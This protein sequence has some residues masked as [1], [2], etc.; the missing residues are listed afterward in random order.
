[1]Y[2]F[3]LQ[4]DIDKEIFLKF[5]HTSDWHLGARL[6]D[7]SRL[8]EQ[9]EVLAEIREIAE[10]E[11]VDFILLAGDIFDTFNPPNEAV[12]LLYSE[13]KKMTAGGTRPVVAI[14]G[15][16]D[17]PDRIESP[18]PLA[19]ECG[20]FFAGYPDFQR[21]PKTLDC[22]ITVSFPEAGV[23]TIDKAGLPQI[24]LLLTPYANEN[25]LRRFLAAEDRERQI[26]AILAENWERLASEYC[27]DQGVNILAAH[28]F[29]AAGAEKAVEPD[30]ERSILHPGG[31]E[32]IDAALVPPQ[33]Q[34]TALGH[35]HRPSAVRTGPSAVVY[36]GSP[37]AFGLSE[38]D[39]QK[40]VIVAELSPAAKAD[41]RRVPLKA[42]RRIRRKTFNSITGAVN[43]L[44]ENKDCYVE[45]L[46]E[47][48][49]YISAE[50][51]RL[52]YDS[53]DGI[54]AVI[55]VRRGGSEDGTDGGSEA[56]MPDI[57]GSVESLFRSFF[58]AQKG[59]APDDDL[60]AIFREVAAYKGDEQ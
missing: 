28:L 29:M 19:A 34:Y 4:A 30:E 42:G 44:T 53:H 21:N 35:L 15:N 36:S 31:L 12:E 24:R 40:S 57:G 56:D 37:L 3:T 25:R 27:D 17:S 58:E 49:A 45:L 32:L 14:A 38:E 7:Y 60:M 8:S 10:S 48:E 18:D 9:R 22:G 5:L 20:I 47:C 39:Q 1:M 13:L 6:G 26:S 43:W 59:V 16:H 50:D 55:P 11:N 23:L 2:N 54:T 51:R 46:I 52:L 41:V 33:V